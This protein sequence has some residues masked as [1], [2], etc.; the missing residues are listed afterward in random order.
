MSYSE[1]VI[2]ATIED[3]LDPNRRRHGPTFRSPPMNIY[4]RGGGGRPW[5]R[6]C[7]GIFLTKGRACYIC[8]NY[9]TT[10]DHVKPRV[11]GGT[12]HP[13]NLEPCCAPCNS[14]R[15]ALWLNSHRHGGGTVGVLAPSRQSWR[16]SRR[17]SRP[18]GVL[19]R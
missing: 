10:I 7:A 12:D 9:A 4:R 1:H 16:Q 6:H 13:S 18:T 14:R 8:G 2:D 19:A 17:P 11:E 3:W 15:G 5:Q